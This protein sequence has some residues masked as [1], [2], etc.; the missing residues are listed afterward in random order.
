MQIYP[1]N[2]ENVTTAK[3][4]R[5]IYTQEFDKSMC[6]IYKDDRSAIKIFKSNSFMIRRKQALS[7]QILLKPDCV[8][9]GLKQV[10]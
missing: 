8:N 4:K 9:T 6:I 5:C 3:I 10:F 7:S 1:R 2:R